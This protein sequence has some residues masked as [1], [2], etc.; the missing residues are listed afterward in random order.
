MKTRLLITG[1]NGFTG[2]YLIRALLKN[3]DYDIS[4]IKRKNSDI[5]G[6]KEIIKKIKTYDINSSYNQ[7]YSIIKK[8]KPDLVIHL[9]ATYPRTETKK[10]IELMLSSNI[11]FGSKLLNAMAL[12]NVQKF[13][14]TGS[15]L[16]FSNGPPE[17]NPATFYST[18]KRAFQ[19]II[20]YYIRTYNLKVV[21]LLP[22]NTY[23]PYDKR[24]NFFSLLKNCLL[25]QKKIELTPGEQLID[26]LYI[27]DLVDAYLKAIQYL[28]KKKGEEHEKIFIG[29]GKA[30]KLKEIVNL[31]KKI[32]GKDIPIIF[33]AIPYRRREVM[34]AQADVKEAGKKLKWKPKFSLQEGIERTLKMDKIIK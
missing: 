1:A 32:S 15:S 13:L 31:Y 34:F 9:A 2:S 18:T 16:E 11:I 10:D 17:Y 33:G 7:I 26:L 3:P 4:I 30:V 8:D 29:S 19:D 6:I 27:E 14:N 12:N 25:K 22:Y 28:L 20:E 5:S 21:T 24:N 23:G